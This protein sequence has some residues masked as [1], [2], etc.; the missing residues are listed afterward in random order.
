MFTKYFVAHNW[1]NCA[2]IINRRPP[3]VRLSKSFIIMLKCVRQNEFKN[4]NIM[5]SCTILNLA[6]AV[7]PDIH[8]HFVGCEE[9]KNVLVRNINGAKSTKNNNTRERTHNKQFLNN[10]ST[11]VFCLSEFFE[12]SLKKRDSCQNKTEQFIATTFVPQQK[13]E[14]GMYGRRRTSV[15][16]FSN[17]TLNETHTANTNWHLV[18]ARLHHLLLSSA[19]ERWPSGRWQWQWRSS[20]TRLHR[21]CPPSSPAQ[22][23]NKPPLLL[24]RCLPDRR[25]Q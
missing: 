19:A 3:T 6:L 18:S 24:L 5:L 13:W 21:W 8:I 11:N 10:F 2:T 7:C 16:N 23:G 9:K 15:I 22:S 17:I 20:A 1:F 12:K 14:R 25:W 4:C